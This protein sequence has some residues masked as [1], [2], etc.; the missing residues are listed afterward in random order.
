[1]PGANADRFA[2]GQPVNHVRELRQVLPLRQD[3]NA[4]GELDTLDA[5]PARRPWPRRA[6]LPFLSRVTSC[7]KLQKKCVLEQFLGT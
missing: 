5:T 2:A 3:G 4:A 7:E 1:M 6:F